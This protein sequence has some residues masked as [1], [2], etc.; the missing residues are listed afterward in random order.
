MTD[1]AEPVSVSRRINAPAGRIFSYLADP[2]NHP[3]IDGSGMLRSAGQHG[4]LSGAG[5]T[6]EMQMHN[7]E[8]GD[9]EMSNHVVEFEP[10]RRIFWEPA[11]KS[12]TRA[13]DQAAIGDP[14]GHRWGFELTPDGADATT[15][16]EIFDCSQAP[17]WLREVLDNGKR[18]LESMTITLE[19]LDATFAR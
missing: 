8:M 3:A 19:K 2:A 18:W 5:D 16:T 17:E 7:D 4:M 14:A 15:V 13:E 12:A 9:Y 6:F 1:I 11:L 10:N